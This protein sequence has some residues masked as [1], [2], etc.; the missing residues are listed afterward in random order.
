MCP[1]E[2]LKA[3]L[4]RCLSLI[5]A[6]DTVSLFSDIMNRSTKSQINC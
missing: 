1:L 2:M 6:T 3:F 4:L 5:L